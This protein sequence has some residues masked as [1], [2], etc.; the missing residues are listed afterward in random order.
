M[1]V[2]VLLFEHVPQWDTTPVGPKGTAAAAS[3]Q[4]QG[5]ERGG[6]GSLNSALKQEATLVLSLLCFY[7]L[8]FLPARPPPLPWLQSLLFMGWIVKILQWQ[9]LTFIAGQSV[10]IRTFVVEEM[11]KGSCCSTVSFKCFLWCY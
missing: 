4:Q 1:V 2:L 7:R 6:N 5:E 9:E 8:N 3:Q 11:L 10:A